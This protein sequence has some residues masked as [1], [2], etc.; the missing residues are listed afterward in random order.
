MS[1]RLLIW[2]DPNFEFD[3][4][5]CNLYRIEATLQ[6]KKVAPR[7]KIVLGINIESLEYLFFQLRQLLLTISFVSTKIEGYLSSSAR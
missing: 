4:S 5:H 3:F 1:N 6:A 7:I 2:S